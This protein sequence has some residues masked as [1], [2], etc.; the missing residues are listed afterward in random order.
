MT[1][2]IEKG[3]RVNL[4]KEAAGHTLFVVGLGWN[5][6]ADLDA[7]AFLCK[8]VPGGDAKCV[9]TPGVV[10]FNQ[11]EAPGVIHYGDALTGEGNAAGTPDEY[12]SID[13]TKLQPEVDQID[14]WANIYQ[15]RDRG[16][17]FGIVNDAF[18]SIFRG[19]KDGDKIV[20]DGEPL[21]RY[22]LTEDSS[23]DTAVQFGALYK[24]DG[25]WRFQALNAG[26]KLEINELINSYV[27]GAV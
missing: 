9:G 27:P 4:Q 12:I 2:S 24:K 3:Q 21:V 15:A 10:F 25:E 11:K 1:L 8:Q 26:Q 5:T 13:V 7:S 16:Q 23:A 14:I 18:I 20:P 22:D 6:S 19:K 17:N